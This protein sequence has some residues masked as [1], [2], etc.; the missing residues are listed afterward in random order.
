MS[1][2]MHIFA[3]MAVKVRYW[4]W[5]AH[6]FKPNVDKLFAIGEGKS[7]ESSCGRLEPDRA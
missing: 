7:L 6:L 3:D 5:I 2:D 4:L 1:C